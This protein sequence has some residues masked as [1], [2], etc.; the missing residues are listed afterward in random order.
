MPLTAG[1]PWR[2]R[3][4]VRKFM[5]HQPMVKGFDE[6]VCKHVASSG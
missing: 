3:R 1:N 5:S 2:L 4:E 6:D